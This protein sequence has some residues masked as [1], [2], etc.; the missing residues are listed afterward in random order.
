MNG[1]PHPDWPSRHAHPCDCGYSMWHLLALGRLHRTTARVFLAATCA[2]SAEELA[3]D[4]AEALVAPIPY[5]YA[6]QVLFTTD[7]WD[8]WIARYSCR[9]PLEIAAILRT[10]LLV[11]WYPMLLNCPMHDHV[12]AAIHASARQCGWRM[13][14]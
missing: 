4:L 8:Q 5:C 6:D 11:G 13:Q 3:Y 2:A 1:L 9:T 12:R 14:S 7:D 10:P